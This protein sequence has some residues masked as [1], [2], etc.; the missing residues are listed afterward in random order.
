MSIIHQH[1]AVRC[2]SFVLAFACI[3][4]AAI[5]AAAQSN[6]AFGQGAAE[7]AP[8]PATG[9][10]RFTDEAR[11]GLRDLWTESIDAKQERVACLGGSV[12]HGVAYVTHIYRLTVSRADSMTIS[13]RESLRKCGPPDWLGTVHT[14]IAMADGQPYI[15]F[16]GSDLVVMQMWREQWKRE[17][18]FCILYSESEANCEA[19]PDATVRVSYATAADGS[20]GIP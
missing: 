19:R 17:G 4:A 2:H 11:A 9:Q 12:V 14:H 18:V 16:S 15:L 8:T 1:I 7:P 10:V 3:T 5:P 13:A 20:S 6:R